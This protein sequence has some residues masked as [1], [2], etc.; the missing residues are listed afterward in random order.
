M[1][2]AV[3]FALYHVDRLFRRV[4]NSGV[5]YSREIPVFVIVTVL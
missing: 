3:W 2:V 4:D 5:N 1:F